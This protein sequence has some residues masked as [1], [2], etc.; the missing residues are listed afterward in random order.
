MRDLILL[1]EQYGL[2]FVFLNVLLEQGGL[3]IP[4]Y[5]TLLVAAAL[6]ASSGYRPYQI[7]AVAVAAAMSADVL[8][9]FAGRRLGFRVLGK[10][11]RVS[12]S[13]DSCVRK[14]HSLFARFGP[15]SLTFAKFV[16]GFG[17]LSTTMAGASRTPLRTFLV[18]DWIGALLWSG[19]AVILGVTFRTA[20]DDVLTVLS[21]LGKWGLLLIV[22]AL[23]GY[24]LARWWQRW[25]FMQQLRMDRISV[26]ELR[27][28][29]ASGRS[30]V[31]VDVRSALHRNDGVIPGAL[32][33][34]ID[35]SEPTIAALSQ[36]S[37]V[38]LYCACPNEASAALVARRLLKSGFK[39]VRPLHGGIDAWVAAGHAV[40]MPTPGDGT[41]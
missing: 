25:R 39:R 9:Y 7:V 4:A 21:D 16:P 35:A 5:P 29:I 8:W 11:C 27:E 30:P 14:T 15:A 12:L 40:E 22:T 36:D 37:E 33:I 20:I 38:V 24:V 28:L 26:D 19:V 6:A 32:A 3:P 1:I 2:P 41:P 13:P 23:A 10:L 18:L 17:L 31:I 34:D